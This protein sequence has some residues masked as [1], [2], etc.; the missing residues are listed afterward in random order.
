M[1]FIRLL[2][3]LQL[4]YAGVQAQSGLYHASIEA[5]GI[6]TGKAN[7]PFWMRSNQ[8][9]SIPLPGASGSL[10]A[11]G[12]KDYDSASRDLTDWGAG[13]EVRGDLGDSSRLTLIQAYVKFRLSIF[14]FKAGRAKE[15]MGLVD[16]TLS[17]GA[18][19]ESGNALPIPKVQISIPDY[20]RLPIFN[21]LFSFKGNFAHGWVGQ[22]PVIPNGKV[23]T[24]NTYYHQVSLYGRLGRPN[25]K[26]QLLGGLN[27]QAY[28]GNEQSIFGSRYWALSNAETF[29]YVLLGKT[30]KGSKVGNHLGSIDLGLEYDFGRI[31]LFAYRQNFY[32]EGALYKLANIVDGLN[33]ISLVNKDEEV[34]DY[35]PVQGYYHASHDFHWHKI[36][37]ELFYTKNQA[38]YPWSRRTASG[39]ENYYNNN[40]YP[41]GWSYKGLGLGNPFVTPFPSTRA[42]L[43]N[44]TTDFFNNNRVIALYAGLEGSYLDYR[45]TAKA[46]YSMNYGTYGTSPWGH[47]TGN[48]FYP[49]KYGLFG[50]VNQFS[51]YLSVERDIDPRWTIGCVASAD[52]G[53][54]F[55]NSTGIIFK[56]RRSLP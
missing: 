28:W 39:D 56:I 30:Y 53:G 36:V 2:L 1:K 13:F 55:Y 38:G 52:K 9:G 48:K 54:L 7:V 15:I 10:I 19:S 14:E 24:A 22:Q 40:S 45:F 12:R 5:Q 4:V 51:A 3:L 41:L 34:P 27:H 18:F 46:S 37:L 43:V 25:W 42:N 8:F 20:F 49:P 31:K 16:T 47:S 11:S 50:K 33:G 17:S 29:K 6:L 26:L 21:G 23:R 44:D 35:Y 32:D